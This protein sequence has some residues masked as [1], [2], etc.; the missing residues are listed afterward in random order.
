MLRLSST[1]GRACQAEENLGRSIP[2]LQFGTRVVLKWQ[3]DLLKEPLPSTGQWLWV[4]STAVWDKPRTCKLER[5]SPATAAEPCQPNSSYHSIV[6]KLF[7]LSDFYHAI[8]LNDDP[9]CRASTQINL[10]GPGDMLARHR[11]DHNRMQ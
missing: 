1:G 4:R 2:D 8:R 5:P 6:T 9:E 3:Q 7:C 10:I 11:E